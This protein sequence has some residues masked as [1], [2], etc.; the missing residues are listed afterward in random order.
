MQPLLQWKSNEY[1]TTCVCVCVRVHARICSLRYPACN[2]RVPYCHLSP[3]LLY[4]IFPRFFKSSTIK[5][6]SYVT[7]KSVF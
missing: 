5:K 4:N 2:V 3:A 7:Q 6:K 1:Y